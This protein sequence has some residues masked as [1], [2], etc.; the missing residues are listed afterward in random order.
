MGKVSFKKEI[1]EQISGGG[2][3]ERGGREASDWWG[4]WVIKSHL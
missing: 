3:I 1:W 2:I 4:N